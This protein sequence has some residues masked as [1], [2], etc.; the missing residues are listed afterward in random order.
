MGEVD[1]AGI[2]PRGRL[3]FWFNVVLETFDDEAVVSLS[4]CLTLAMRKVNETSS[5]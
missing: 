2:T 4:L 1:V 5:Y 3:L